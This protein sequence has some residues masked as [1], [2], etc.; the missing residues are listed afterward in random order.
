M[1]RLASFRVDHKKLEGGE[2]VRPDEEFDDLEI[3]TRGY[4]DAY[5]DAR[6]AKLRRAALPY[7]GDVSK[8]PN[9]EQRDIIADCLVAHCLLDVRNLENDDGQPVSFARFCEMVRDPAYPDLWAAATRAP[10]LVGRIRA[11]EAEDAVGNSA[12]RSA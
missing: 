4:T 1:A 3:R 8:I 6:A 11:G 2:W 10:A 12:P 5:T 9:A 7:G